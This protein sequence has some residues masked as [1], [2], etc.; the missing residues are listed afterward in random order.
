MA[1]ALLSSTFTPGTIYRLGLH[2]KRVGGSV[3]IECWL[4]S[5]DAPFGA[6]VFAGVATSTTDLD[7]LRVGAADS[8]VVDG[9]FDNLILS[10][11]GLP[12]PG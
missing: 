9:V 8:A 5:G 2:A 10:K 12:G 11:T 7:T 1:P 6:R 4:A 3:E